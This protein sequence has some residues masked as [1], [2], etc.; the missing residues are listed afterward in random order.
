MLLVVVG[1]VAVASA[2]ERSR[3][4]AAE[5]LRRTTVISES[6][7]VSDPGGIPDPNDPTGGVKSRHLRHY[8]DGH[9]EVVPEAK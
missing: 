7:E 9:D 5:R 1:L 6:W 4:L 3:M 2:V 8:A